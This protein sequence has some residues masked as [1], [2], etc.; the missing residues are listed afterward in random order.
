MAMLIKGQPIPLQVNREDGEID[1]D[2]YRS[3]DRTRISR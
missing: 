1:L 3:R 2:A